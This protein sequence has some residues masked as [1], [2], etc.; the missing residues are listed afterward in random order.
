MQ[1]EQIKQYQPQIFPAWIE[2]YLGLRL[3]GRW[4]QN[5]AMRQVLTESLEINELQNVLSPSETPAHSW[6]PQDVLKDDEIL[7]AP[8]DTW[9]KT[10]QKMSPQTQRS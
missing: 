8:T 7:K 9:K 5:R 4:S 2:Y 1:W 3:K 10:W 6:I